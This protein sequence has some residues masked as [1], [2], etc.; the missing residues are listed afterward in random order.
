MREIIETMEH[1]FDKTNSLK[2]N[3]R[4]IYIILREENVKYRETFESLVEAAKEDEIRFC[5]VDTTQFDIQPTAQN[6]VYKLLMEKE[7]MGGPWD[8]VV[9]DYPR[10]HDEI[11]L[12]C[13]H[14]IG[15][16]EEDVRK[17][18]E[19][20]RKWHDDRIWMTITGNI[21][22]KFVRTSAGFDKRQKFNKTMDKVLRSRGLDPTEAKVQREKLEEAF[23]NRYSTIPVVDMIR[24]FVGDNMAILDAY[25]GV[26]TPRRLSDQFM[27]NFFKT[28]GLVKQPCMKILKS[29]TRKGVHGRFALEVALGNGT[30]YYPKFKTNASFA[31]YIFY[32]F[33]PGIHVRKADF[34]PKVNAKVAKD[35]CQ[36]MVAINAT[37]GENLADHMGESLQKSIKK[38]SDFWAKLMK[39][40]K[41]W[42]TTNNYCDIA[43]RD[44]MKEEGEPYMIRPIEVGHKP[45]RWLEMSDDFIDYNQ[46][47]FSNAYKENL[48]VVAK[49]GIFDFEKNETPS[50]TGRKTPQKVESQ[51]TKDA[52]KEVR[53]LSNLEKEAKSAT[54]AEKSDVKPMEEMKKMNLTCMGSGN[55]TLDIIIQREYPEGF[56]KGKTRNKF[57]DKVVLEELGGTCG[58]VMCMMGYLGWNVYP[59][60]Q[61]DLHPEGYKMKEDLERY[62]CD[63]RFVENIE[64]GGSSTVKCTHK[65]NKDTGEHEIS[66][67]QGSAGGS[68]FPRRKQ[69]RVRDEVPA[70]LEA[71]DFVPDVFFFDVLEAGPR[72]LAQGLRAKGTLVYFEPESEKD[73]SKFIKGVEVSDIVKFSGE[74]VTDIS[75][76]SDYSDKLFIQ[77]LGAD[78]LRFSLCGRE[79]VKVDAVPVEKVVD[80]EG[81]GDTTT[82]VFLTE[83]GKRGQLKVSEMTEEVVREALSA[84]C[85]QAAVCAQYLSSKGWIHEE[86]RKKNV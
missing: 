76:C 6:V 23:N 36:K 22:E 37:L 84:A 19:S 4:Q 3:P 79:W 48:K 2:L 8:F 54:F 83:L 17:Q 5:I 18:L 20:L 46:P 34:D 38:N 64:K 69:L 57:E 60:V 78:G 21:A 82:S 9:R 14:I 80:W 75:F 49:M 1:I 27:L 70:F 50:D 67:V 24:D 31:M 53:P 28:G 10:F 65:L 68:R 40:E 43:I 52:E 86:M 71:L 73:R 62:G 55:F 32:M 59:Q 33:N 15:N 72:A 25:F 63:T 11:T 30:S 16:G 58:N 12:S 7:L 41:F 47:D 29:G 66:F 44:V 13:E 81:C 35:Y 74:R 77:T 45:E 26:D 61:F 51:V 42:Q 85:R 39:D 56:V